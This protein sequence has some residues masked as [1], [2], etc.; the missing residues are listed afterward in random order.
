MI[1]ETSLHIQTFSITVNEKRTTH[2]K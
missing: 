2:I 1:K